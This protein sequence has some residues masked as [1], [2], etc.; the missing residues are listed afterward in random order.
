[1]GGILIDDKVEQFDENDAKTML[2]SF[3][4]LLKP[5]RLEMEEMQ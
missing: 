5:L 1:M 2:K 3:K 4:V